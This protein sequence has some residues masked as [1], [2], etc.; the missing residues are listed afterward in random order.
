MKLSPHFAGWELGVTSATP[1]P[2]V[3]ALRELCETI[4]EPIRLHV[5]GPVR[6][7]RPDIGITQRGWRDAKTN[8]GSAT[9]QHKLGEAAD[10]DIDGDLVALWRWI[11]WDSGIPFGQCILERSRPDRQWGWIHVSLGAPWRAPSRCGQVM[12][13]PGDGRY[14]LAT[15][16][17]PI[18]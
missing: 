6:I 3:L 9:S 11:A 2:H 7:N 17:T 10:P 5:G 18:P 4:L 13:A 15:P 1:P 8:I 14:L 16:T 12:I